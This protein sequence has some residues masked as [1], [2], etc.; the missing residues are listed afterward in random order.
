[1]QQK[2]DTNTAGGKTKSVLEATAPLSNLPY[3]EQLSKKEAELL[4]I[5]KNYSK[6]VQRVNSDLQPDLKSKMLGNDGLPCEWK[7]FKPSP[8]VNSY[9]NKSEFAV[10]MH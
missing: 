9:R 10:G 4:E 1:M 5:L 7:G 3:E 2:R 8:C 6:D